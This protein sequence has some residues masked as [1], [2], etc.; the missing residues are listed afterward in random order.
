M[1][2]EQQRAQ[3]QMAME[4]LR[5]LREGRQQD[6]KLDLT[7]Q[8]MEQE[9]RMGRRQM[10][11]GQQQAETTNALKERE[12]AQNADLAKMQQDALMKVAETKNQ[13]MIDPQIMDYLQ[14]TMMMPAGAERDALMANLEVMTG[15]KFERPVDPFKQLINK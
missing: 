14:K 11:F 8:Q 4:L 5:M 9:A 13:G 15:K 12:L 2:Q 10:R 1:K 3:M 7:R 6:M